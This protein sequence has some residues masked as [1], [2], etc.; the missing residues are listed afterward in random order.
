MNNNQFSFGG[1]NNGALSLQP[2]PFQ[3]AGQPGQIG[4][5]NPGQD[6]F[7]A[8]PGGLGAVHPYSDAAGMQTGPQFDTTLSG[9]IPRGTNL[10]A[11]AVRSVRVTSCNFCEMVEQANMGFRPFVS[12]VTD[13]GILHAIPQFVREQRAGANYKSETMNS[14]VNDIV[15]LSSSTMGQIP[16]VNGWNIRRYSFTLMAEVVRNNGN[17]Q[18]YMIEGFTDTPDMSFMSGIKVDP[19]MVLHVNNV[20]QF[21]ERTNLVNGSLSMVPVENYGVI[22]ADPFNQGAVISDF[23]TQRP[24]DVTNMSMG[25]M[26]AGNASTVVIDGRS[27]IAGP[28]KTSNLANNNPA[29]YVAKIINEG[30]NTINKS[31]TDSIF[32]TTAMRNMLDSVSEPSLGQ[33]GFLQALGKISR[34]FNTAVSSFTW[35]D[36]VALDPALSNPH[37]PY[38]NVYPLSNRAGFLPSSGFACD[39]ITGSGNEQVFAQQIANG[40]ADIMARCE[41]T[42]VSLMASNHSNMDEVE[43]TGMQCF[44][45]TKLQMNVDLLKQLFVF[46]IMRMLNVNTQFPYNVAVSASVWGETFVKID[47]GRGVYTFLIPNFANSMFSPVVTNNKADTV[48]VSR[49]LL[50]IANTVSVEQTNMRAE[51]A[52]A[53]LSQSTL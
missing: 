44:D 20:V 53:G 50:S 4:V 29:S 33:N 32:S 15:S 36:L 6:G 11:G 18:K 23:V 10:G 30:I 25:G 40:L 47:L 41:A 26:L 31:N 8:T 3:P 42:Q 13:S 48:E 12:N 28:A 43:V 27:S 37:C 51:I 2:Q 17:V 38:L 1:G 14:I 19:Q 39:D 52:G 45:Q 34:D 46:N 5:F 16:I 24:Y 7:A 9:N 49:H 22:S 35:S 21:A